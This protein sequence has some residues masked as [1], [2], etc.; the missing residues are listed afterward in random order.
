M[1]R[2][3]AVSPQA[4][5]NPEGIPDMACIVSCEVGEPNPHETMRSFRRI[6]HGRRNRAILRNT[7]LIGVADL[8][9]FVGLCENLYA[10]AHDGG[11]WFN[12]V[13]VDSQH[14]WGCHPIPDEHPI[15][16]A[17]AAE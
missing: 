13:Y 8:S 10:L 3:A 7:L 4:R 11:F 1:M 17:E 14:C 5:Q 9:D 6:I 2:V 16:Y 15:A 12:A